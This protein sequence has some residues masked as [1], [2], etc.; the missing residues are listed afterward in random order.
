[1]LVI[2]IDTL[3]SIIEVI[4]VN[5]NRNFFQGIMKPKFAV[6]A[7]GVYDYSAHSLFILFWMVFFI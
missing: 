7:L 1:V 6:Q 5:K 2:S 3:E 4:A